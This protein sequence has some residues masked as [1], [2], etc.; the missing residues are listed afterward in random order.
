M[1]F[2]QLSYSTAILALQGP[3][4]MGILDSALGI[5]VGRF[6]GMAFISESIDVRGWVQGTGYTG[7][8]GVEI[9]IQHEDAPKVWSR[10]IEVGT[11]HGLR[12]VGLG[13]R[14]TLR[15][16]KGYLL[17]GQD[18]VWPGLDDIEGGSVPREALA[19]RS[20]QSN[21]PFGIALDVEFTG[22]QQN[23]EVAADAG[24]PRLVGFELVARGPPPRPGHTVE[25]TDGR[26]IGWVTSGAPSPSL[27]SRGIG[28]A[29]VA[30]VHAGDQIHIRSSPR[31]ATLAR[32]TTPPFL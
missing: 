1:R 7:E 27:D 31:R 26:H 29:L 2:L 28:L 21:V 30:N 8:P 10:L 19:L 5:T 14:D 25:T 22:R 15:L 17:S 6:R 4:A 24:A 3:E 32:V 11:P 12:P 13:A 16:E 20:V 23:L 9:M 18:F